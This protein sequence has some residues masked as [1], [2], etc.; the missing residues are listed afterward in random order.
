MTGIYQGKS[1]VTAMSYNMKSLEDQSSVTPVYSARAGIQ[2]RTIRASV[3]RVLTVL[4][5]EIPDVIPIRYQRNYHP[6]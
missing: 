5:G 3:E 6:R 4:H 2:Q 1:R